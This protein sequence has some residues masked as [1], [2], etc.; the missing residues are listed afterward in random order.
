MKLFT[1]IKKLVNHMFTK[2]LLITNVS[3]D[4]FFLGLGDVV[5]QSIEKQIYVGKEYDEKRTG[6]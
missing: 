5:Q 2:H 6:K 1:K 4:T 3:L